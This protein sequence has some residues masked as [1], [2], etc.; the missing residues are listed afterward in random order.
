MSTIT[1]TRIY[2]GPIE[3]SDDLPSAERNIIQEY[4]YTR[5]DDWLGHYR[6]YIQNTDNASTDQ[7]EKDRRVMMLFKRLCR[8]LE[9]C[10]MKICVRRHLFFG[11]CIDEEKAYYEEEGE[12]W[13][14]ENQMERES[15]AAP[16]WTADLASR[17]D[18]QALTYDI[19]QRYMGD[20]YAYSREN[21]VRM[22]AA[23]YSKL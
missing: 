7:L 12:L 16:D 8:Q 22:R 14:F 21:L 4:I 17:P 1:E 6:T 2:T 20:L 23:V 18:L 19:L 3:F 9:H 11:D 5:A 13:D 10:L 15:A